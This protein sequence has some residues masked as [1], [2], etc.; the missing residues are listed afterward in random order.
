MDCRTQSGHDT[1]CRLGS[2][3]AMTEEKFA[4]YPLSGGYLSGLKRPKSA[5]RCCMPSAFEMLG[6]HFTTAWILILKVIMKREVIT[7]LN[8]FTSFKKITIFIFLIFCIR[9]VVDMLQNKDLTIFESI[10]YLLG[11]GILLM[12]F[13]LQCAFMYFYM[14]KKQ[15]YQGSLLLLVLAFFLMMVLATIF[16]APAL[17]TFVERPPKT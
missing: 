16:S 3:L 6:F 8:I 1:S 13:K 7:L 15:S 10:S 12:A 11:A 2:Y 4:F 9:V 17:L 5:T 14:Y